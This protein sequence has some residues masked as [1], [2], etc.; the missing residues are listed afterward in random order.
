MADD[1]PNTPS[2]EAKPAPKPRARRSVPKAADK[3]AAKTKRAPAKAPPKPR[4]SKRAPAAK[5][6]KPASAVSKATDKV[7]G[8]WGVAAIAGGV[9]AAA[10]G[11]AAL[12]LK[13]STPN[14]GTKPAAKPV[15]G[16]GAQQAD[17]TDS[18]ASFEAGIADEGTVPN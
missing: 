1:T 9:V 5:T 8:K 6:R 3:P 13:G 14:A 17:G 16:H 10:A 4:S 15:K 11:A 2:T 7:G 18:S 12:L